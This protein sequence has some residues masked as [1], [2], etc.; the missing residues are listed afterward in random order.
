[1]PAEGTDPNTSPGRPVSEN[2]FQG[3]LDRSIAALAGD[4]SECAAGRVRVGSAP[5]R[6][7]DDIEQLGAELQALFFRYGEVLAD[8]QVPLPEAGVPQNIAR[9]LPESAGGRLSERRLVEPGGVVYECGRLQ[10]RVAD[11]V[12]ELVPAARADAGIIHIL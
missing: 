5:V 12:P 10:R 9:L 8:P 4:F 11:Q 3:K 1:M 2:V 7:I 6:M